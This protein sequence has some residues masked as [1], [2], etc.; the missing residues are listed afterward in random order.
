MK[1]TGDGITYQ[2]YIKNPGQDSFSKSSVTSA[3]Y[4]C[5]MTAKI[6]GRQAYCKITDKYGNTVKTKT[7]NLYVE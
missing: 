4:S 1:A 2:W 5:K 3:T 6:S 7:V